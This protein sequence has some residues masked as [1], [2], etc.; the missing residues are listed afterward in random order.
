ML[1]FLLASLSLAVDGWHCTAKGTWD[2]CVTTNGA[3]TCS[4]RTETATGMHPERASAEVRAT[5]ACAGQVQGQILA[6]NTVSNNPMNYASARYGA[7]C[8]VT[9]CTAGGVNGWDN[10]AQVI[11][12]KAAGSGLQYTH[13]APNDAPT[14]PPSKGGSQAASDIPE[15]APLIEYFCR[16]CGPSSSTCAKVQVDATSAKECSEGWAKIRPLIAL[17]DDEMMAP[18]LCK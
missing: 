15:C 10:Q 18:Q 9:S 1:L 6:G 16:V 2:S 8:A 14:P 5:D 11:E 13:T 3:E 12:G 17:V 7:P 4:T